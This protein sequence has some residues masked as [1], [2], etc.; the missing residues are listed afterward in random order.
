MI[1]LSNNPLVSVAVITYNSGKTVLETLE[2]VKGQSYDNLELIISDDGS[3][4][5]TVQLCRE[6]ISGNK[7]RFVRT[8]IVE[9]AHNTGIAGNCN[10]AEDACQ[11]EWIKPIAGDDILMPACVSD[12]VDFISDNPDA[13]VV[14]GRCSVFGGN[15]SQRRFYQEDMFKMDFFAWTVQEQ[16]AF[17]LHDN[18]VPAVTVFYSLPKMRALGVHCDERI[19]LL[20]DWPRWLNLTRKGVRLQAIDKVTVKYRLNG[21]SSGKVNM[22]Y[23]RSIR[24]F[25][26]LYRYPLSCDGDEQDIIEKAVDYDCR[27]YQEKMD[28][29]YSR[30]YRIG[31]LLL[32]PLKRVAQFVR[33][34]FKK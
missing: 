26:F 19:P 2:S 13:I 29:Y 33:K 5:N 22:A 16:F 18:C 14:F 17:L 4:D 9:S 10:R 31:F 28:A 7:D 11:G 34:L 32:T 1:S 6:W 20:E 3:S 30:E 12:Y 24:L 23:Y 8:V 21:L 25:D 27:L 15:R